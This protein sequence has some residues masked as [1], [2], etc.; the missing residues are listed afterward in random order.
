MPGWLR[1]EKAYKLFLYSAWTVVCVGIFMAF[2][3]TPWF[4]QIDSLRTWDL[5]L[6]VL[7][8]ALG[9]VGAPAALILWF[10]MAEFC[11]RHDNSPTSDKILWFVVF[12]ATAWFGSALYFFIVY[13]KRAQGLARVTAPRNSVREMKS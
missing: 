1:P 5:V 13:R 8:G 11:L 9:I 4:W 10:G 12:F 6:R 3:A 2:M 7:G